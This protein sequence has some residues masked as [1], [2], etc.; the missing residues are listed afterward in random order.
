MRPDRRADEQ[1]GQELMRAKNKATMS[2]R[3]AIAR[4]S[5]AERRAAE[6]ARLSTEQAELKQQAAARRRQRGAEKNA[7]A[8]PSTGD[9]GAPG[10]ASA[11]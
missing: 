5:F 7:P 1:R 8:S 10:R 4:P 3:P 9:A 11:P 2:M 6:I